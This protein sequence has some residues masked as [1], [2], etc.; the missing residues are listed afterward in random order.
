MGSLAIGLEAQVM[1]QGTILGTAIGHIQIVCRVFFTGN[2]RGQ[3]PVFLVQPLLLAI[4]E[5]V[6]FLQLIEQA[7]PF[8]FV[9]G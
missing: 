9:V 2:T 8:A 1:Q 4:V 3:A 7:Q 6:G 5:A